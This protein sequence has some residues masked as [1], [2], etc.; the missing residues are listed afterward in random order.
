VTVRDSVIAGNRVAPVVNV[1]SV[2]ATCASGPCPFG[3]GAG[4]GIENW[5]A[6]TLIDTRVSDNQAGGE[7]TSDAQGGGILNGGGSLTL[8][9]SSITRNRAVGMLPNGRFAEGGGIF[10]TGGTLSISDS[11]I[12]ENVADLAT[13]MLA[14][15]ETV[16][17]AGGIHY[18]GAGATIRDTVIARNTA[19]ATN[20]VGNASAFAGGL[21]A[22]G[23]DLR[24]SSVSDNR[25]SATA[26]APSG[27]AFADTGG[28]GVGGTAVLVNHTRVV[29]NRVEVTAQGFALAAAGA[30]NSGSIG[31][32]TIRDSLLA[33]NSV[34]ATSATGDVV[35]QGAGV[36]NIGVLAL[37]DTAVRGNRGAANGSGGVAEGGGIWNATFDDF[38]V[39]AQ[40]SL[41]GSAI[42][43][44]ALAAFRGVTVRGGGL[45]TTSP[46]TLRGS[47]IAHNAPDQCEGCK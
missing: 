19:Q 40:L 47:L 35:V 12:T 38:P 20:A 29:G 7:R 28:I 37:R 14:T 45:F 27:A 15:V 26:S 2:R 6:L 36:F 21:L 24:D 11:A 5:G 44:N 16:A 17:H 3:L 1:A 39:P 32:A 43:A 25:V 30:V 4:G 46:V 18:E 42:S 33:D 34:Q 13:S 22:E 31:Q 41:A 9:H 23:V 8:R 10:M